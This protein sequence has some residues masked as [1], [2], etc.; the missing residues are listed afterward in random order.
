MQTERPKKRCAI[1]GEAGRPML[2]IHE[3]AVCL[4]CAKRLDLIA[5]A[6]KDEPAD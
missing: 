4:E 6:D 2:V 1:C 3:Q 5:E